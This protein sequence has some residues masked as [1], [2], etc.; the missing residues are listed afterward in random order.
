M[1]GVYG[2][3][4]WPAKRLFMCTW[5]L[6][7]KMGMNAVELDNYFMNSILPLFPDVQ[8]IPQKGVCLLFFACFY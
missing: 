6:N 5:G 2:I 7:E 8:Y 3:F 4:G 1:K